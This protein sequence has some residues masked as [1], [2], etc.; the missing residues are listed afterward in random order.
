MIMG[1]SRFP[2]IERG[3]SYFPKLKLGN[4]ILP[5][6]DSGKF[7]VLTKYYRGIKGSFK[8]LGKNAVSLKSARESHWFPKLTKGK[9][10]F[11]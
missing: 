6:N 10:M 3:D 5:S 7:H 4:H 9:F 2:S 1:K 11:P 8:W